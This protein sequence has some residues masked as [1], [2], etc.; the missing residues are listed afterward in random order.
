M[1][2]TLYH[3]FDKPAKKKFEKLPEDENPNCVAVRDIERQLRQKIGARCMNMWVVCAECISFGRF[4]S[5]YAQWAIDQRRR[6][7]EIPCNEIQVSGLG[8]SDFVKSTLEL[9]FWAAF[10]AALLSL[11]GSLSVFW[12]SVPAFLLFLNFVSNYW[13]CTGKISFSHASLDGM[14]P[15][16][17]CATWKSWVFCDGVQVDIGTRFQLK[18]EIY[19]KNERPNF[20]IR[21]L[22]YGGFSI[23]P[24]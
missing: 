23:A 21:F 8:F 13:C 15:Q 16:L 24:K 9:H 22:Q 18:L 7:P 10:W 14:C 3:N 6:F 2:I 5:V 19:Q 1:K 4:R 20:D 17:F 12:L 11:S